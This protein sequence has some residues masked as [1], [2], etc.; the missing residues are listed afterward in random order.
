M[1]LIE[2]GNAVPAHSLHSAL[3]SDG[4]AARSASAPLQNDIVKGETQQSPPGVLDELSS[5]FASSRAALANFLSLLTLEA[6]RAG[7]ALM[8]MVILG[9]VAAVC[10]IAAWLGLMVALALW[11]VSLGFPAIA[12]VVAVAVLN[13]A[14]GVVLIYVCIGMSQDLLFSATRRQ[15]SGKCPAKASAS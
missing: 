4:G 6:R 9:V 8:W 3:M 1:A 2:T 14:G 5:A 10:A 11:A 7:L 13:L 12:A 15:V